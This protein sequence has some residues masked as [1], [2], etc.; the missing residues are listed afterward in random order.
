MYTFL[1]CSVLVVH[2]CRNELYL[3]VVMVDDPVSGSW[4]GHFFLAILALTGGAARLP[5]V[6]DLVKFP[7]QGLE[8]VFTNAVFP[9]AFE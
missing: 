4:G 7:D 1:V 2:V 3:L 6:S 9:Y 8:T 5:G